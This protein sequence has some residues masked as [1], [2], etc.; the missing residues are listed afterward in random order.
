VPT[1]DRYRSP[2]PGAI[3]TQAFVAGPVPDANGAERQFGYTQACHILPFSL[4][5]GVAVPEEVSIGAKVP[6]KLSNIDG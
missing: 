5:R 1:R 4:T 2:I 6:Y 3:D